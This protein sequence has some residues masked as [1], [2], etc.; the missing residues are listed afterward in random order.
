LF[1]ILNNAEVPTKY[2]GYKLALQNSNQPLDLIIKD[3]FETTKK[4]KLPLLH[5]IEKDEKNK[6]ALLIKNTFNYF[7]DT[8]K[9]SFNNTGFVITFSGVDGAGKST[10]IENIA[11]RIEKQLRKPVVIL[12]HRPSI[13]PILS[14]WSKGKKQ[15]HLDVIAGLPRQ[16]KNKS[17]LSSLARFSYYY[18]DYLLGQ[19]VVYFKYTFRGKVVIYDRYYFDFINDSKRS[20]I[21]LP[22]KITSFLYRFLLSPKF[23]FFLFADADIILKRK[24]ELTKATIEKLTTD[25]HDLF[26]LLQSKSTNTVYESINNLE[27]ELTLNQVLKTIVLAK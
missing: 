18:L 11:F 23:N 24:E 9:N 6:P 10:V 1:Y 22:K 20:N 17:I 5:F 13:L 7:L 4:D 15:A 21:V 3:Y 16:G 25:Y 26:Q 2:L 14:V 12:R 27:L 8:L 19:F